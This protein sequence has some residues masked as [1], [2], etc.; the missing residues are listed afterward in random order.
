MI[1]CPAWIDPFVSCTSSGKAALSM[2]VDRN[3]IIHVPVDLAYEARAD[4]GQ[5]AEGE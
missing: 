1:Q 2:N 4:N 3:T 5:S